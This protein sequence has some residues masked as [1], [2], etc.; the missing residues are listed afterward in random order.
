MPRKGGR[1][2]TEPDSEQEIVLGADRDPISGSLDRFEEE[3]FDDED[4]FVYG[5]I[6]HD[7][8]AEEP[9]D[10]VVVNLPAVKADQWEV[11]GESLADKN[12]E[13]QETD[14]VVVV[15]PLLELEENFPEWNERE[16]EIPL[17][18]LEDLEVTT[19]AYPELR[20]DFIAPSHLR[21]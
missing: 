15:S 19:E 9:E 7:E 5:D 10:L 3:A 1:G 2:Q 11:D 21:D 14:D 17:N 18:T 4:G 6:V 20:L 13:C 8:K 16:E 12:P